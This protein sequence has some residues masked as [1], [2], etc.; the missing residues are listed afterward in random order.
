M[1]N[2]TSQDSRETLEELTASHRLARCGNPHRRARWA[3]RTA[4][5]LGL[6]SILA[7]GM[8]GIS[9][10][11]FAEPMP[12]TSTSDAESA[13]ART[14]EPDLSLVF[15]RIRNQLD[16]QVQRKTDAIVQQVTE[17]QINALLQQFEQKLAMSHAISRRVERQLAELSQ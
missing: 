13:M 2:P 7:A 14:F 8:A 4:T 10:V 3:S 15:G 1:A 11:A 12:A 16:R 5:A 6:A 9:P 17:N